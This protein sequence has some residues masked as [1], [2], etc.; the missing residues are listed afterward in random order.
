[1]MKADAQLVQTRLGAA[2]EQIPDLCRRNHVQCLSAFGSVVGSKFNPV[3]S[4]LDFAVDFEA[5]YSLPWMGHISQL[6]EDMKELFRRR[7][8]VVAR[9]KSMDPHLLREIAETEVPLFADGRMLLSPPEK[10]VTMPDNNI[11]ARIVREALNAIE[12]ACVALIE[13][14]REHTLGDYKSNRL[15]KWGVERAFTIIGEAINRI[16]KRS[17]DLAEQITAAKSIIAFRNLIIHEYDIVDDDVVW[18]VI[19]DHVPRLRDEIA[20]VRDMLK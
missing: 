13:V 12:A 8:D 17:P 11:D 15:L 16:R 9:F 10:K 18:L 5:D 20:K 19:N 7:V 2:L 3:A 1:M 14:S 6:Q 4:D